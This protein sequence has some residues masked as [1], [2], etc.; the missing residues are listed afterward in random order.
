MKSSIEIKNEMT[1]L[2]AD[3]CTKGLKKMEV[4]KIKKRYEFLKICKMYI[5]SNPTHEFL[6]K[7]KDRLQNKINL[8]NAGYKPDQ[9]LIDRGFKKEEQKEHKDYNKIMGIAK[10]KEQLKGIQYLIS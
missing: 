7:E 6:H 2:Q 1:S 9:K 3:L 4:S 10:F 5:E 8:I